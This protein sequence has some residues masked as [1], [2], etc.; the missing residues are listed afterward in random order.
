MPRNIVID[1]LRPEELRLRLDPFTDKIEGVWVYSI[2]AS[3]TGEKFGKRRRIEF[4]VGQQIA[5][6][7][8]FND[9]LSD[10]KTAEGI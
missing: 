6:K 10:L 3:A 1:T 4:T 2:Q 9:R 8:M 5:I 7:R